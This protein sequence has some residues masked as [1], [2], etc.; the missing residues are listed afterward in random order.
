MSLAVI[1]PMTKL[2]KCT[3][4]K[5]IQ[6]VKYL[7]RQ[8]NAQRVRLGSLLSQRISLFACGDHLFPMT[9]FKLPMI[10]PCTTPVVS[11]MSQNFVWYTETCIP[12]I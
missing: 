10:F 1:R 7:P 2:F 4:H 6:T 5:K 3:M 12:Q 8:R 11:R 9:P